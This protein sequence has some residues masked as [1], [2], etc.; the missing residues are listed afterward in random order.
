MTATV[1]VSFGSARKPPVDASVLLAEGANVVDALRAAGV[2][3]TTSEEAGAEA[4]CGVGMVHALDGVA[5]D[6]ATRSGWMYSVNGRA[7]SVGPAATVVRAG[8]VIEWTYR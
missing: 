5:S 8:D 2:R 3:V 4:C 1:R 7:P 6:A